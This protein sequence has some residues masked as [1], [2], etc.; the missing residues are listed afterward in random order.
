MSRS[1]LESKTG[2]SEGLG[3]PEHL[4][5]NND[6]LS[7]IVHAIPVDS[8]LEGKLLLLLKGMSVTSEWSWG[9]YGEIL[10][11]RICTDL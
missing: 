8:N 2:W 7:F 5:M 1:E 10:F 4:I 3:D 6:I 11:L 9:Y